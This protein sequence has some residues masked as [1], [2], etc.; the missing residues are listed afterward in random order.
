MFYILVRFWLLL[1]LRERS[2]TPL[3]RLNLV[4]TFGFVLEM[5]KLFCQSRCHLFLL[6]VQLTSLTQQGVKV[7]FHYWLRIVL[8]LNM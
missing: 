6:A 5:Q 7:G 3:S 4:V 1:C 8:Y 2:G